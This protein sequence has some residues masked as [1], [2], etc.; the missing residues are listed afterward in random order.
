[1]NAD[2]PSA[3]PPVRL[4]PAERLD[5]INSL[6]A[7]GAV[8]EGHFHCNT[9]QGIRIDGRLSG[10]ITFEAG[11]TLHIGR[12]GVVDNT[13]LQA[14]YVLIEGKVTGNVTARKAL[15]VTST[16]TLVGD[17][18]Y[19]ESIDIHPRARLRGRLDYQGEMEG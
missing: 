6:I 12:T 14:D 10:S 13:Q 8:F 4:I 18:S 3:T 16:G 7:E 19:H 5:H 15:E 2:N 11:G 9:D 17:V 1:M